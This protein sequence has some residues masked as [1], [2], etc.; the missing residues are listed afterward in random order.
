VKKLKA[1]GLGKVVLA[2]V[3]L[4]SLDLILETQL[5]PFFY[6]GIPLPLTETSKP[7]GAALLPMAFFN[8]LL[9]VANIFAFAYILH[10]MN[11]ETGL[12][13]KNRVE[14]LDTS[15][16]LIF[17]I[18]GI[19]LWYFPILLLPLLITGIYLIIH[20]LS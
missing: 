14:W 8:T 19:G 11:I 7:I 17:L 10:R 20:K 9:I 15:A 4:L 3:A 6:R 18:S 12:I 2:V 1:F 5:T 16:F 13:P